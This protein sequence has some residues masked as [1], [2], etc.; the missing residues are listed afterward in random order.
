MQCLTRRRFLRLGIILVCS[1]PLA[2]ALIG[3]SGKSSGEKKPHSGGEKDAG[4]N[5][6]EGGDSDG[7]VEG[8]TVYIDGWAVPPGTTLEPME[9]AL[10]TALMDVLIPGDEESPGA[11]T[12]NAPWYLDQLLG[13]FN[14]DPPRIYAG[15]PYSGRHGGKDGFSQ[16]LPLTRVEE[17]RWRTYIEGSKGIP[18]REFNGTVK[19]ILA[20]YREG[21]AAL[22][23]EARKL[24]GGDFTA[25]SFER[26]K[27]VV[28]K[29]DADFRQLAYEHAVEGTYGD[30]IYGGNLGQSGWKALDYEGDRQ[31]MG[32]SARQM[33]HPEEG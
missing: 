31:P 1:S 26:R 30:P 27:S 33:S 8:E 28:M 20:E 23:E 16:F 24:F 29:M 9:Y 2:G 14:Y 3:C 7:S 13:A 32:Y 10:L 25:Q 15:A 21:L 17:I 12:A 19:G 11:V 22:N 6:K 18:E 5:D 4:G